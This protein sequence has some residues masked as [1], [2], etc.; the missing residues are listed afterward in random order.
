MALP[1]MLERRW[2]FRWVRFD[3]A[4]EVEGRRSH[5][6]SDL[7]SEQ[8]IHDAADRRRSCRVILAVA[9]R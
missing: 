8:S 4:G 9:P 3:L 6:K 5:A 7:G 1:C 2:C